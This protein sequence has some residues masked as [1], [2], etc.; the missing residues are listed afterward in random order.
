MGR[1]GGMKRISNYSRLFGWV[2]LAAL[3]LGT[4]LLTPAL[5]AD[6]AG[7]AQAARLSYVDGQVR[8]SQGG[9][10]LADGAVANTPLFEG[11]QLM[12]GNDGKA[13]IQFDDGSVVRI[14]PDS[15]VTLSVLS[16]TGETEIVLTGGLAYFELQGGGQFRVRFSGSVAT[17]SGFSVL[18]IRMDTP[19]G[20]LSVFSGNAHLKRGSASALDLH[21]G[22][23]VVLNGS[24]AGLY[25]LTQTIEPDSWDTW[26]TDRDQALAA[27]ASAQTGTADNFAGSDTPSP[28]WNDLDANGN[29][30][31]VPGEGYIW[32][33]YAASGAGW[34]PYGNGSW[35]WTSGYGYI[36]ASGYSWGYMPYQCG[37][38]NY[39]DDFGWGWAPGM[40]G[41]RGWWWGGGHYGGI[42]IGRAPHGYDPIRRPVGP[43]P[44]RGRPRPVI[45]VDRRQMG[46]P[47]ILPS[48][49]RNMP[50]TIGGHT[51]QALR[52][53]PSRQGYSQA[54]REH[55]GGVSAP[56]QGGRTPSGQPYGGRST[57]H[58]SNTGG[59]PVFL[60]PGGQNNI[61]PR[62]NYTAP[63]HTNPQPIR[64][65]GGG[66]QPS[67]PSGGGAPSGGGG[68]PHSS[69]GGG[70][71]GSASHASGG[72]G[73]SHK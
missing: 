29:W 40:G 4:A 71:G 26:N 16:G 13:E 57:Y 27:E 66:G 70:G 38:W 18:R 17:A 63:S 65:S 62:Q 14:S 33:P 20:E 36:W 25:K 23:S 53:Q 43:I 58:N 47:G 68:V 60:N 5:W 37:M 54:W 2:G 32:S 9:Q 7:P 10:V 12:T 61:T 46:A 34:D 35:T 73:G 52:P 19:P 3:A 24:D 31:N 48:R 51:V 30:Y 56:N 11:A 39:Y 1:L 41:C 64:P 72:S 55:G 22:E 49:D 50:V 8:I 42:N 15:S 44:P 6:D 59:S 21:G 67:R 45:R 28:A 69:G